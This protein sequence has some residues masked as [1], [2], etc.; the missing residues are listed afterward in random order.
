MKKHIVLA[1]GFS[2]ALGVFLYVYFGII[3]V[4]FIINFLFF[5]SNMDLENV[6]FN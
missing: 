4:L 3:F 6:A 1:L 5:R 2:I